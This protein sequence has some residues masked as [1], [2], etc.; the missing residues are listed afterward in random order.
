VPGASGGGPAFW[1]VDDGNAATNLGGAIASATS[2]QICCSDLTTIAANVAGTCPE[3]PKLAINSACG[4]NSDCVS[5]SC[6]DSSAI[7]ITVCQ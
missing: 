3:V 5:N 1:P 4:K 6:A 7:G 2:A